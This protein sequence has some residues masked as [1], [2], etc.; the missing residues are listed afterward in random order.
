[1]KLIPIVLSGGSGTRLWPM[2]RTLFPKQFAP[3]LEKSLQTLTLE[4]LQNYEPSLIVTS[5]KLSTLTQKQIADDRSLVNKVIYEPEGKNTAAAI[6]VACR[7]LQLQGL[8][9]EV[10]GVFSSDALITNEKAFHI[11]IAKAYEAAAKN[12][13]VILGIRPERI[14]TGFGYIQTDKNSQLNIAGPV[15]K[16][17]EKPNYE[18]AEKF[19]QDGHYFWNAG[20]FIFKVSEMIKHF[21][22]LQPE[23]WSVI[24][25]LNSQLDNFKPIYAAVKSISIDF[26]IIEKLN[27]DRLSCVPCDIGW[28]DLGSWD[29]LEQMRQDPEIKPYEVSAIGNSVFSDQKKA[30]GFVG[31]D[32]LIVVDTEDALL[33]CQK[34]QSQ[35]VKDLVELVKEKNPETVATRSFEIRPWGQ[36]EVL[37]E[38][39]YYKAKI[40]KVDAG[41]KNSYQSHQHRSEHWVVVKG[42]ATVVLNDQDHHLKA[43]QHIFIPAGAKHRVINNSK[44]VVEFVEVQVGVSFSEKDIVRYQ[45]DYGR[46]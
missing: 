36:F 13:I 26:A 10:V 7:F 22:A 29:V 5:E 33:I 23:M 1:M 16:F 21:Q 3:L 45:D 38:E 20:I 12:K 9:N 25:K 34:G 8:E 15:L 28:S 14:E 17:H 27:S 39:P 42:E 6:A 35:K 18:T 24:S 19:V 41:Q 31:V 43:G 4:R 32:N 11:A 37:K 46:Q 44:S 30:I 2:S 40:I